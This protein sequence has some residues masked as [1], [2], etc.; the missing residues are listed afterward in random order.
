MA[1]PIWPVTSREEVG[2]CYDDT[3]EE[4][5]R[6]AARLT[7]DRRPAED[8]VSEAYAELVRAGRS[9]DV[10]SIG[11]AWLIVT[12]RRRFIDGLRSDERA[13]RRLRLIQPRGEELAAPSTVDRSGE[14]LAPLSE[15]ERA[16]VVLR[17]VEDLPVADVARELGISVRAAE[18]LLARAR[19]RMRRSE[20]RDA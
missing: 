3:F 1:R 14:L 18:S 8:L 10:T 7:G 13:R 6:F 11:V 16:A 5:F 2:A 12:V 15:R 19:A 4:V 20:V 9:G 17:Y